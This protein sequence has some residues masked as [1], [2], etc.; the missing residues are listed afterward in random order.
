HEPAQEEA[1]GEVDNEGAPR[2]GG[3][4]YTGHA[5]ANPP[6][7]QAA[8][9]RSERHQDDLKQQPHRLVL[10]GPEKEQPR[11][12]II[13][14]A[15]SWAWRLPTGNRSGRSYQPRRARAVVANPIAVGGIFA[16]SSHSGAAVNSRL[17][18]TT[19]PSGGRR[20]RS[21]GCCRSRRL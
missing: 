17:R 5:D 1:A 2:E 21:R 9:G 11:P 12:A 20:V 7:G 8:Q 10:Q 3:A 13:F 19:A 14:R 6:P 15:G 18:R 4:Q 16:H